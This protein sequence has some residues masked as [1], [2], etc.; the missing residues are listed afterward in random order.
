MA[1]AAILCRLVTS[2]IACIATALSRN[3]RTRSQ[4]LQVWKVRARL[5][6]GSDC[7]HRV[8][9]ASLRVAGGC[10]EMIAMLLTLL[11]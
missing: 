7:I 5:C 1:A 4:L 10:I 3:M 6:V 8:L 11:E 9:H 2:T